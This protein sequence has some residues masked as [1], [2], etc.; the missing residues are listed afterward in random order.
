[1]MSGEW[2]MMMKWEGL[3]EGCRDAGEGRDEGSDGRRGDFKPV[4]GLLLM[5]WENR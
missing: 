2:W 3:G 1:M 5:R 4:C